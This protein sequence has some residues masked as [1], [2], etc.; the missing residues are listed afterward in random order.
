[1]NPI[2][3]PYTSGSL[4]RPHPTYGTGSFAHTFSTLQKRP[5]LSKGVYDIRTRAGPKKL[6][7]SCLFFGTGSRRGKGNGVGWDG[8]EWDVMGC[9]M[10]W[11]E[12]RWAGMGWD[13]MAWDGMR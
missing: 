5:L 3:Y 2:R 13:G 12:M 6:P 11:D 1:M 9:G 8:M 7:K 4:R 10:A